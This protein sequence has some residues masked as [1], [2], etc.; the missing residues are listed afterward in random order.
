MPDDLHTFL[1]SR[2][3]IR[4]LKPDTVSSVVI[5]RFLET[6][7]C[8]PS[9]HNLQPWRFVVLTSLETKV[10]LAIS[11]TG[12]FQKDMIADGVSE[13][14]IQARVVQ[15][16]RRA[17]EAQVIIVLCRERTKI[18]HQPDSLRQQVEVLLA[19]QSVA[20]ADLQLLL[21]AKAE[22]LGGTW[23]CWPL[24]APDETCRTLKLQSDW[25]P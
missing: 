4:R 23:I 2:R 17:K 3:S 13:V 1:R 8:A 10:N 22:G 11:L 19:V 7:M 9:A 18:K 20:V 24:F 21:A 16:I 14:E 6:A 25:D 12:K 5:Q 15:R